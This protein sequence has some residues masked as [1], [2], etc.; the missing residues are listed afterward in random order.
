MLSLYTTVSIDNKTIF[1]RLN[2]TSIN[3][4]TDFTFCFT[5]LVGEITN[6]QNASIVYT[7][8]GFVELSPPFHTLH[9][10]ED[11]EFSFSCEAVHNISHVPSN[12]FIQLPI[13]LQNK[14]QQKYIPVI[15][16]EPQFTDIPKTVLDTVQTLQK[17]NE[18]ISS[19]TK[20]I[21]MPLA[22]IIPY[23]NTVRYGTDTTNNTLDLKQE[24][25]LASFD[26]PKSFYTVI[27]KTKN[28]YPTFPFYIR[29]N[30]YSHA[31]VPLYISFLNNATSEEAYHLIIKAT[32]KYEDNSKD[33]NK[34]HIHIRTKTTSGLQYAFTNLLHLYKAHNGNIPE[35]YI[36]DAPVHTWRGFMLD[37]TRQ[38][39]SVEEIKQILD[40]MAWY[41]LNVFHWHITDDEAWR[42]QLDCYPQ[43]CEQVAY[44]GYGKKIPP[45]FG[46]GAELYGGIYTKNDI[47]AI[48]EHA[49]MRSIRVIPEFDIPGHSY[50]LIQ[51]LPQLQ[52]TRD[53][54]TYKSV[55]G[56][57]SNTL[58]PALESTYEVLE[59]IF[60]ELCPLFPDKY[61]HIGGDER[62]QKAWTGSPACKILMQKNKLYTF[63]DLQYYFIKRVQKIVEKHGKYCCS[64]E[65]TG[66]LSK[67][68]ILFSWQGASAGE[69]AAKQGYPVVMCPAP[70]CYLDLAKS[71][72]P[73]ERGLLWA[74]HCDIKKCYEYSAVPQGTNNIC[75]IQANLWS[76]TLHNKAYVMQALMPRL[77]AISE[78]A[79]TKEEHM[80][81]QRFMKIV[82]KR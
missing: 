80:D 25:R 33:K 23:P 5:L 77:A 1:L 82:E 49:Q 52:E 28:M 51:A 4:I 8:G 46:S 79:W 78:R 38:F 9:T 55:Q 81:F 67:E 64:W 73:T 72:H 18:H 14:K 42:I 32:Q 48:V 3:D 2:N 22:T 62:P 12:P 74:G 11:W 70:Y 36:E 16:T 56:Y 26:I 50:A 53:T 44:R 68:S 71:P 57:P 6:V 40:T 54:S 19:I 34:G 10:K 41:K 39:Y 13:I 45:L 21:P 61:F 37:T 43:L 59:N 27:K 63:D 75:G 7:L 17:E 76:E 29:D 31:S 24:I 30:L 65:E 69:Q 35:C 47:Q 15:A 60:A 58:N 66:P 20:K